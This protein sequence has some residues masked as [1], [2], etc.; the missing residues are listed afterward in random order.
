[1]QFPTNGTTL[2]CRH[3]FVKY[4]MS[5]SLTHVRHIIKIITPIGGSNKFAK[6]PSIWNINILC[7]PSIRTFFFKFYD[8]I[9][10]KKRVESIYFR[11]LANIRPR[12]T[13]PR[14]ATAVLR[15]N[16]ELVKLFINCSKNTYTIKKKYIDFILNDMT[17]RLLYTTPTDIWFFFTQVWTAYL[18]VIARSII[19]NKYTYYYL[20][21]SDRTRWYYSVILLLYNWRVIII[22]ITNSSNIQ[23]CKMF[24]YIYNSTERERL[25]S[26]KKIIWN[27]NSVL[28]RQGVHG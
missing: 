5:Q 17:L 22:T 6:I 11:R 28:T 14:A 19:K 23:S 15:I 8:R 24:E 12:F 4:T 9:V 27:Y 2:R 3:V 13:T 21:S 18:L 7:I 26:L 16:A 1:M 25:N 20:Y 10:W